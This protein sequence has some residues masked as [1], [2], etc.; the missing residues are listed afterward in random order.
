MEEAL[1]PPAPTGVVNEVRGLLELPQLLLRWPRLARQPRG[2]GAPLLVLPGYGAGDGSTGLLRADLRYLGHDARGWR[3]GRNGGDVEALVPK[4]I[5]RLERL[6]DSRGAPLPVVGW[7]LGGVI[8]RE[9][10]RERP[11]LV[12]QIVTLGSP[13]VGGPKYT[14]VAEAY[15]AR[16]VDL[17]ALEAEVEARNRVR[18]ELPIT[19]IYSRSDGVVAWKACLDPWNPQVEHR[20][21]GTTHL[22]LGFSPEVYGLIA[23]RL[24]SSPRPGRS[25]RRSARR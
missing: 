22:G 13:V 8:G 15:R 10:A 5:Q 18:L 7:S 21:V 14:L 3:L 23:R 16:G 24:G 1:S 9:A 6:A 12:S 25:A 2:T 17:D 4:V 20:E 19:A 11:D